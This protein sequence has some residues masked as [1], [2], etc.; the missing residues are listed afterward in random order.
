MWGGASRQQEGLSLLLPTLDSAIP[1]FLPP[2]R[3]LCLHSGLR[4][5]PFELPRSVISSPPPRSPEPAP[6]P[7]APRTANHPPCCPGNHASETRRERTRS[8]T[9]TCTQ[10]PA[11]LAGTGSHGG[12]SCQSCFLSSRAGLCHGPGHSPGALPADKH[13][14]FAFFS[15]T[16]CRTDFEDPLKTFGGVVSRQTRAAL[17]FL[18]TPPAPQDYSTTSAKQLSPVFRE[19]PAARQCLDGSL[20]P[21]I[22]S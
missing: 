1:E 12:C 10:N 22:P 17:L 7:P 15:L 9:H 3:S 20:N 14:R 16:T 11:R 19:M 8:H 13:I 21:I 5:R 2:S 18:P 4:Q 6:L